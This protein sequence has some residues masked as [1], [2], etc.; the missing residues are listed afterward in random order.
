MKN[1]KLSWLA[2][3]IALSA[4]GA[5]IKLP[6]V[7]GS[8]ALDSLPA[9]VAAGLLGG[10]AGAAVGGI[11]HLL[12]AIIAGM[13]L[14]PFHFLIAGEMAL[15]V[16]LFGV[17][18]RNDKRWSAVLL[19]IIGNSFAAPLPFIMLMGK[20]FYLAIVPSLLIGSVLNTVFAYAV[21]PRIARMLGPVLPFS[22]QA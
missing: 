17:L 6:A 11:G 20:S 1:K 19:F 3:F 16:F 22:R 15:L 21:L 14:G 9:L 4:A 7:I 18:Y 5:S 8:V 13:P 10:P 12:S 2:M